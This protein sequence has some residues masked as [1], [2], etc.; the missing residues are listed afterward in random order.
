MVKWAQPASSR[1]SAL[2]PQARG[3]FDRLFGQRETPV[4]RSGH[5]EALSIAIGSGKGGTGKSFV[6]TNLAVLMHQELRKVTLVDCDFGLGCA[7]LLLGATPKLT[8]HD[9]VGGRVGVRDVRVETPAGPHLVPGA[10]GVRHMASLSDHELQRV[11][12]ALGELAGLDD[13]LV[14]DVGAGIAAQNMLAMLCADHIVLVTEAEIAALTDA[15]AVIKCIAQLREQAEVSVVV[16]RVT[17]AGEGERTFEK[18][19]EVSHRFTAVRLGFL[20]EVPSDPTVTRRRLGQLPVAVTDPQ[21]PTTRALRAVL[22]RL[23]QT[24]GTLAARDVPTSGGLEARFREH[25]LFLG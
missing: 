14:L 15:Y 20:G 4:R 23:E 6:A 7:H 17:G 18:L 2:G 13:V 10:Q 24:L 19:A 5:R 8:L 11:G 22:R 3:I 1:P 12:V 21:G 16:N 9:L 25:R